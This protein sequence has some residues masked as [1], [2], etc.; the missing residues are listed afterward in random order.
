[1]RALTEE[2]QKLGLWRFFFIFSGL[3]SLIYWNFILNLV[4]YFEL[5]VEKGFFTY[6]TF[7]YSV[8]NILSF[9]SGK[10]VFKKINTRQSIFYNIIIASLSFILCLVLMEAIDNAL[11]KKIILIVL[12]FLYSYFA[13]YFQGSCSGYASTCG[14]N[15]IS[16]FTVGTGIAGVFANVVAIIFVFI[17]PTNDE[18]QQITELHRQ[19]VAY[20]IF[21]V[22]TFVLYLITFYFYMKKFGHFM[23]AI[24]A[25]M[26]GNMRVETLDMIHE[27]E[28]EGETFN[29]G[30]TDNESRT[31]KSMKTFKSA[32][33]G[34]TNIRSFTTWKTIGS[35]RKYSYLSV[36]KRI[37]D[38]FFAMIF[39]YFITIQTVCFIVPNL[40]SKYDGNDQMHILL[41]FSV[42]N[43]G[44]TLGK[45]SPE[46]WNI[47]NSFV[48][49][50]L[51]LLRSLIQV[52]F[53]SLIFA[54]LPGFF[55]SSVTRGVIFF[56]IGLTNGYFTNIYFYVSASRFNNP[57]NKAFG[58][59]LMI[60][61]LIIGVT[62]GTLGGVL[63]TI[64]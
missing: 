15:S 64:K 30:K 22:L 12:V 51:T 47:K 16:S 43:I 58:G 1:M 17:F 62:C 52:L 61:G 56:L 45:L 5:T 25:P 19:M 9:M 7:A 32:K 49:H 28:T 36:L 54:D 26:E 2:Q 59:Y 8:G 10:Y 44:D 29:E 53:I 41:Y 4:L 27:E 31:L 38:I 63:W 3:M 35:E 60:F 11:A 48:M 21:I 33:T 40:A 34:K 42:Y 18:E 24:D 6:A 23:A 46:S 50:L 57:K 55:T 39:T 37:M 14:P 20:I 13:G